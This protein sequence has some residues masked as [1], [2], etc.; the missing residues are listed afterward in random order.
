M[1]GT[2]W[3]HMSGEGMPVEA[4]V[5][6][7]PTGLEPPATSHRF[8]MP[9]AGTIV[10]NDDVTRFEPIFPGLYEFESVLT[11]DPTRSDGYAGT[12]STVRASLTVDAEGRATAEWL[13]TG[14]ITEP[15]EEWHRSPT[16]VGEQSGRR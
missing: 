1:F 2:A 15:G 10:T 5:E 12:L 13:L 11:I 4:T 3:W 8:D 6:V 7:T 14:V 16:D 9:G